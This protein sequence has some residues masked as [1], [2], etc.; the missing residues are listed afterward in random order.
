MSII[1]FLHYRMQYP[2]IESD[3]TINLCTNLDHVSVGLTSSKQAIVR[4]ATPQVMMVPIVVVII[5]L[6][7]VLEAVERDAA[8]GYVSERNWKQ[9]SYKVFQV[10]VRDLLLQWWQCWL[11]SLSLIKYLWSIW[12]RVKSWIVPWLLSLWQCWQHRWSTL[13]FWRWHDSY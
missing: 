6:I 9:P 11:L 1:I 4:Q 2:N 10:Q 12:W 3:M 8:Q 5:H 7:A 13:C